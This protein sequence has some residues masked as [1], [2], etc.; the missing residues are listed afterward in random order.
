MGK[1]EENARRRSHFWYTMK[2]PEAVL[3]KVAHS[4][5]AQEDHAL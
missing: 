4:A 3:A 1:V 5:M 2:I